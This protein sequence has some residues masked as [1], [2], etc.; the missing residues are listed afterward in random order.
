MST[1]T[2][3]RRRLASELRKLREAADLTI[4]QAATEAKLGKST[5]SR[6]ENALVGVQPRTV[7]GLLKLYGVAEADAAGLV[8]LARDAR[9]H[10]WWYDY[11]GT[12]PKWFAGYVAFE[13]EATELKMYDIQLVNG[14]FQTPDYARAMIRAHFPED[15]AD[16]IEERVELRM[17][18]QKILERADPPRIW[19][20]L[21]EAALA[22]PIGGPQVMT[23]Q[24]SRLADASQLPT[25]TIQVLP[26]SQGAHAGMGVGFTIMDFAPASDPSVVYLENLSG[27]LF[28][29]RD[30]HV[31][32]HGL[33][34]D[35]LRATALSPAD[36][37]TL[38]R[39]RAEAAAD[40]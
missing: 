33:A 22:R 17:A 11:T 37:T 7:A 8:Q 4:E 23:T 12:M 35:H 2:V 24:F 40:E 28:L 6:I 34:F 39:V 1:P 31:R 38:L 36:S 13:D 20:V 26:F 15:S 3:Q 9:Q 27:A 18:R 21:D 29:D 5:L 19:V 16:K 32:T 25:V 30:Y 10:G 14:L